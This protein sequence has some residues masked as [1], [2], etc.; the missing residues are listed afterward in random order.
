MSGAKLSDQDLTGIDVPNGADFS[1][2]HFED[3][4]LRSIRAVGA[5]WK[6]ANLRRARLA[7]S[8]LSDGTF[9]RAVLEGADL[10]GARLDHCTLAGADIRNADLRNAVV[11][12]VVLTPHDVRECIKKAQKEVLTKTKKAINAADDFCHLL[13]RNLNVQ[14]KTRF[15]PVMQDVRQSLDA[16][17]EESVISQLPTLIATMRQAV[18]EVLERRSCE[19]CALEGR[20]SQVNRLPTVILEDLELRTHER[21]LR[22]RNFKEVSELFA[23]QCSSDGDFL[24]RVLRYRRRL[25]LEH[26][27]I[28]LRSEFLVKEIESF[29]EKWRC[30]GPVHLLP[31]LEDRD[32]GTEGARFAGAVGLSDQ[33]AEWLVRNGAS[34]KE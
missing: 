10:R 34:I 8:V 11:S 16:D 28:L 31:L 14:Y 19:L 7:E 22:S 12:E 4:E 25:Q 29:R 20:V 27:Q 23:D 26:R 9:E 24:N 15:K 5:R 6:G 1:N 33:Q 17:E 32:K 21:S 13:A 18:S 3:A 30:A 2:A